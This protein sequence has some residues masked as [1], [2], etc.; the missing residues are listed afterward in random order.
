MTQSKIQFLP[1]TPMYKEFYLKE[2]KALEKVLRNNCIDIHHVGSTA[3]SKIKAVPV[4]DILCIAHT[5]DGISI[6]E[7][8]FNRLGLT[9][10]KEEKGPERMIFER[11][12][13]DDGTVLSRIYIYEKSDPRIDDILDLRDYLNKN[14]EAAKSYEASKLEFSK[15]ADS[16]ESK[17]SALID[18]ILTAL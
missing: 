18:V 12:S 16:Y 1:Y 9:L 3:I 4:L 15:D 11:K 5:L 14:E 8:E 13:K 10:V 2:C 17:K 6:F 7:D